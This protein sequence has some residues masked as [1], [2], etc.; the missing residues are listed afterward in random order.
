MTDDTPNRNDADK[1]TANEADRP[2]R[3]G[4]DRPGTADHG[5]ADPK[6]SHDYVRPAGPGAMKDKPGDWDIV[7]EEA[8]ESFPASDPPGNY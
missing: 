6:R 5:E 7:D 8:D 3:N 1:P 4:T 2:N